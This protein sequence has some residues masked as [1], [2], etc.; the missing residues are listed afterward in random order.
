MRPELSRSAV[1]VGAYVAQQQVA[2]RTVVYIVRFFITVLTDQPALS[3]CDDVGF[4]DG[5]HGE[6]E[7]DVGGRD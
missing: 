4:D 3:G 5:E 1:V 7:L 2:V 6:V